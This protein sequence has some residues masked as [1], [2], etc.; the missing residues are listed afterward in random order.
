[1]KCLVFVKEEHQYFTT[2]LIFILAGI[3]KKNYLPS[4][5][6]KQIAVTYFNVF[7]KCIHAS[8]E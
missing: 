7:H 1:M 2:T 3:H 4:D 6:I 8:L 5:Q